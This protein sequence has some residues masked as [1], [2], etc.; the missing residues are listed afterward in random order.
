[1]EAELDH[2]DHLVANV[3]KQPADASDAYWLGA[4]EAHEYL[5]ARIRSVL[6]KD[7]K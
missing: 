2:L 1:M 6:K 3:V 4:N 5:S 7:D